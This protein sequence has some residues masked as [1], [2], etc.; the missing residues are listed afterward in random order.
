MPSQT[1]NAPRQG[2]LN[3]YVRAGLWALPTYGVANLVGTLSSQPDYHKPGMFPAYA[4]YIHTPSFLASH[5]TASMLGTGIGLLGFTARCSSIWRAG[6]G[7]AFRLP[8][9]LPPSLPR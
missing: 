3:R 9:S 8:P 1:P 6:S 4:R 2:N 5:L 7:P